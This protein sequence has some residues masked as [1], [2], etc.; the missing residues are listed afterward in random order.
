MNYKNQ[1]SCWGP[2]VMLQLSFRCFT[3]SARNQRPLAPQCL[4]SKTK[5][6]KSWVG[7]VGGQRRRKAKPSQ[8]LRATLLGPESLPRPNLENQ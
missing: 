3:H 2:T 4:K 7:A 8:S 5:S 1:L 6:C